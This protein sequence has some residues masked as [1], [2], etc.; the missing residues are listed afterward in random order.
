M[1][2]I[3]TN[4]LNHSASIATSVQKLQGTNQS[5]LNSLPILHW[6]GYGLLV[7]SFLDFMESTIPIGFMDPFWEFQFLGQMVERVPVPLLGFVLVF[8]G[9]KQIRARWE[10]QLLQFLS[11]STI[12]LAVFFFL[13]V[14]L[15]VI[16]TIRIYR[17]NQAQITAQVDQQL[18]QIQVAKEQ[19]QQTKTTSELELFLGNFNS[20]GEAPTIGDNQ[21]VEALKEQLYQ[22]IENRERDM[23][24]QAKDTLWEQNSNLLKSSVKWNLGALIAGALFVCLWNAT[25]W[26]RGH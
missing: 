7:L 23:N 26:A 24:S 8:F 2:H 1:T 20:Q 19:L 17:I 9:R 10:E 15:G 12:L 11:W 3:E 6:L 22:A 5:F 16:D 25:P 21:S 13:L 18:A 4:Q 14:P